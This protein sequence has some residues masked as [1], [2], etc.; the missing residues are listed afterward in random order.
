L[1]QI[2]VET[3]QDF[4]ESKDDD[5]PSAQETQL[6]IRFHFLT[7]FSLSAIAMR[8][9]CNCWQCAATHKAISI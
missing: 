6:D 5:I 1:T 2:W 4:L 8:R 9:M 3:T 7:L